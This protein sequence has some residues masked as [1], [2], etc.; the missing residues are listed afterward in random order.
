M[1]AHLLKVGHFTMDNASNNG[2]MMQALQIALKDREIQVDD[3][4]ALDRRI[5]CFAHIINL[6]SGR[7]LLGIGNLNPDEDDDSF[8]DSE[9]TVSSNPI[10][11]ARAVVRVLRASGKRRDEFDKV[12]EKGNEEGYWKQGD[13]PRVVKLKPLQLL[14]DV[15]TRWDSVYKML[16][17]LRQMRPV[18]L[19]TSPNVMRTN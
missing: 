15:C 9:D 14:R 4:D 16:H 10:V 12:L 18:C 3:F 7:V 8:S 5:M 11:H 6:C 1:C 2:S 19:N 13:P 17:R